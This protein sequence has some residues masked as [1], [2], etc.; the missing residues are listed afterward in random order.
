MRQS[1]P[2]CGPQR[3]SDSA[4]AFPI[5]QICLRSMRKKPPRRPANHHGGAEIFRHACALGYEG[6]VSKR[7]GLALQLGPHR[8]LDQ[9][10]EPRRASGETRSGR[11]LEQA[12]MIDRPNRPRTLKEVA[13]PQYAADRERLERAEH[14]MV[15]TREVT[16]IEDQARNGDWRVEYFGRDSA[17][18]VTIFTG[19]KAERR[20]R[21][22][23]QA[24]KSGAVG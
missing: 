24:L 19:P 3:D 21:D 22:Y 14:L 17:G 7:A 11:G 16:I 10:Q 1:H 5:L 15:P 18:Y 20:A 8:S 6:T 23:F 2:G 12:A 4:P 9:G 13:A